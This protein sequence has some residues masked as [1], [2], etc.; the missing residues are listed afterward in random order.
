VADI[1]KAEPDQDIDSLSFEEAFRRLDEMA[2]SLDEGGLDLAVATARYEEGM[3]LVRRC[4]Q[5]LD[6]AELKITSL[7][8][9]YAAPQGDHDWPKEV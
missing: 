6:E 5:L 2:A 3:S 9:A 1:D 8:D 7:K 4:S